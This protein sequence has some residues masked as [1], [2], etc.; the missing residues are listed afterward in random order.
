MRNELRVTKPEC[1]TIFSGPLEAPPVWIRAKW[2]ANISLA[3]CEVSVLIQEWQSDLTLERP[4]KKGVKFTWKKPDIEWKMRAFSAPITVR[5]HNNLKLVSIRARVEVRA[6]QLDACFMF[7][8]VEFRPKVIDFPVE[9][10][11][12][13]RFAVF[14]DLSQFIEFSLL[15][16][17]KLWD[18]FQVFFHVIVKVLSKSALWTLHKTEN[19]WTSIYMWWYIKMTTKRMKHINMTGS[20]IPRNKAY[21]L[22]GVHSQRIWKDSAHDLSDSR[23]RDGDRPEILFEINVKQTD[24]PWA[25]II[26]SRLS[27][28]KYENYYFAAVCLSA[29]SL[30]KNDKANLAALQTSCMSFIECKLLEVGKTRFAEKKQCDLD[31]NLSLALIAVARLLGT[32]V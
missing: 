22:R 3:P 25:A 12:G 29:W 21:H 30:N 15:I 16:N 11:V 4:L 5:K 32:Q 1:G 8:I 7:C 13:E 9:L 20:K 14:D 2:L 23:E 28:K 10:A 31:K 27:L 17:S 24:G 26:C 18:K 6:V 19:T